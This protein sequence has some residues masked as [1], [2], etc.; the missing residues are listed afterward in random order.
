MVSRSDCRSAS[1]CC[2]PITAPNSSSSSCCCSMRLW[3]SAVADRRSPSPSSA[4]AAAAAA[5]V[6]GAAA[7]SGAA[8]V[9]G[10]A[11]A[12][13]RGNSSWIV[14]H[15]AVLTFSSHPAVQA[16]MSVQ[17]RV[18]NF[19]HVRLTAPPATEHRLQRRSALETPLRFDHRQP[20][21][22]AS[23]SRHLGQRRRCCRAV[24]RQRLQKEWPHGV[25]HGRM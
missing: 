23:S 22:A 25:V 11:E 14:F 3:Y 19:R 13:A 9:I 7:V 18:E 21:P 1:T 5:S 6:C 17:S 15:R 2:C 24:R 20:A 8:G 4:A 12:A 16:R 10:G